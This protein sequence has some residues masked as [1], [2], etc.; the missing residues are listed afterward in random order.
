M[1][2]EGAARIKNNKIQKKN[3]YEHYRIISEPDG[4]GYVEEGRQLPKLERNANVSAS[5]N[6]IRVKT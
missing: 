6:K 2:K 1:T 5:E 3:K 4:E